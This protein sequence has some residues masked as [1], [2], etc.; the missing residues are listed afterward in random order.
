MKN[1]AFDFSFFLNRLEFPGLDNMCD[2]ILWA[3][4]QCLCN[5]PNL[6]VQCPGTQTVFV[7]EVVQ[8]CRPLWPVLFHL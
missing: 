7:Y 3:S 8:H 4:L 6:V 2:C 5:V 1:W